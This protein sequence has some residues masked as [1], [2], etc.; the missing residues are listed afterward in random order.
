[1]YFLY[2]VVRVE[3]QIG[4]DFR[5]AWWLVWMLK[6]ETLKSGTRKIIRKLLRAAIRP[7]PR[8]IEKI[9]RRSRLPDSMNSSF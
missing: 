4:P 6:F 1:M 9:F 8:Y 7:G 5:S 3:G 2:S